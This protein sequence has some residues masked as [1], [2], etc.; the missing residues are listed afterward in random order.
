VAFVGKRVPTSI[1]GAPA[2]LANG[3]PGTQH[4]PTAKILEQL[5]LARTQL[6]SATSARQL[7]LPAIRA[8]MR[9]ERRLDRPLRLAIIGEFNSGKS[10]LANLLA[11]VESLPTAVISNT[12]I[13]TLLYYAHQPE[14]WAV[15][16]SGKREWLRADRQVRSQSILQLE[17]G[18]PSRRLQTMQ[19]LDLPGLADPR[20]RAPM[21]DPSVHRIDAIVWCT[22]STQAW[23]E[24]ERAAWSLLPARLRARSLLVS[25]HSDLLH[26]AR[27]ADKLLGRLRNEAGSWFRDII[28]MSNVQALPMARL[29]AEGRLGAA[30]EATGADALEMALSLLL[31]DVYEQRAAAARILTTRIAGIT[32]ARLENRSGQAG[33]AG[34]S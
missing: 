20:T 29:E 26:G 5:K 9:I 2:G 28:L 24:S 3:S 6:E 34:P 7:L 25:T 8:F 30:S 4:E 23:K 15:D 14:I 17:V 16:A 11:G 12:R 10:S 27:D 1:A 33:S 18:L 22:V 13:P 31:S 19:I 32:L 21:V